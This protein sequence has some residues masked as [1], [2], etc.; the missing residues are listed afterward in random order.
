MS[1]NED[2]AL[3]LPGLKKYRV[4][5]F[6]EAVQLTEDCDLDAIAAWCGGT[7]VDPALPVLG[8]VDS[9]GFRAMAYPGDWVVS[10]PAGFFRRSASEFARDYAAA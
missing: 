8:F 6:V 9:R 10:G 2:Q 5:A 4:L 3:Q 7:I 1:Q